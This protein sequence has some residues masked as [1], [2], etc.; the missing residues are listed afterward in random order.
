[1]TDDISQRKRTMIKDRVGCVRTSTYSLPTGN[2]TYGYK[3]PS[4]P[5]G[6]GALISTW[7]TANPSTHVESSKIIVYSNVLAVKHGCVTA[8]AMRQYSKDHPCI[9]LKEMLDEDSA[10]VDAQYE[11]PFGIKTKFAQEPI[12]AI[13][14]AKYTNFA[15]D[16]QDYPNTAVIATKG[17]MP[18]P[19]PTIASA[20]VALARDTAKE[21]EM[22]IKKRFTMRKF[23]NVEG[24]ALQM[25]K[26]K[27]GYA[28]DEEGKHNDE[29]KHD[30]E[31]RQESKE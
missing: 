11:G 16:D 4:D 18:R 5:E 30:E 10:Q 26:Q 15:T 20:S 19:R 28:Q 8:R 23:Q 2:H 13:V 25:L 22:N 14:Q 21:K 27:G 17:L 6:A 12:D 1:M 7:V 3:Q 31:D 24:V 29:G 9:R